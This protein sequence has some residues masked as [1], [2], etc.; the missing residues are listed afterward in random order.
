MTV[1]DETREYGPLASNNL[2]TQITNSADS[3]L[4]VM[5]REHGIATNSLLP[6]HVGIMYIHTSP[7]NNFLKGHIQTNKLPTWSLDTVST[8]LSSS[9]GEAHC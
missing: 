7:Y 8:G 2:A 9:S 6:P 5:V 4:G 3:S 1:S